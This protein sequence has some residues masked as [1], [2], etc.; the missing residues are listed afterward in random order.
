MMSPHSG[1]SITLLSLTVTAQKAEKYKIEQSPTYTILRGKTSRHTLP[2]PVL[3]ISMLSMMMS[4]LI[5]QP[6]AVCDGEEGEPKQSQLDN[7]KQEGSKY[8]KHHPGLT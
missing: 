2:L 5:T 8:Q 3:T 4:D 7:L 1:P 6:G